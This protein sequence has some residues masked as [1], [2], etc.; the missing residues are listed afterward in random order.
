LKIS[1]LNLINNKLKEKLI[2]VNNEKSFKCYMGNVSND[3]IELFGEEA[4]LVIQ[5]IAD[6]YLSYLLNYEKV[7]VAYTCIYNGKVFHFMYVPEEKSL[8]FLTVKE[9]IEIKKGM[10]EN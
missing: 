2:M 9:M 6:K 1:Y 3:F 7:T 10:G 8:S 4:N 5:S